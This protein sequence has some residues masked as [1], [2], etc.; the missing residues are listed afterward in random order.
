MYSK[1]ISSTFSSQV[2]LHFYGEMNFPVSWKIKSRGFRGSMFLS[3][4]QFFKGGEAKAQK[5]AALYCF[6][7]QNNILL[8][9]KKTVDGTR[10]RVG[11]SLVLSAFFFS[12]SNP[13]QPSWCKDKGPE[14]P[15][16]WVRPPSLL[17]TSCMTMY[18]SLRA[19]QCPYKDRVKVM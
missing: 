12:L 16:P 5:K 19:F 11:W 1:Y 14:S 18:K 15:K 3:I 6:Q 13:S 10:T 7:R 2:L 4:L 9:K 17:F 8:K